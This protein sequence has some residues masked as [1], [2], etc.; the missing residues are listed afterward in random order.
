MT[1]LNVYQCLGLSPMP[2]VGKQATIKEWQ[3]KESEF[4][5]KAIKSQ[6]HGSNIAIRTGARSNCF[7]VDVDVKDRGLEVWNAIEAKHGKIDTYRVNTPNGGLHLYFN[8]AGTQNIGCLQ[9]CIIQSGVKI[10][11]D[12]RNDNG[13]VVAP[14]SKIDDRCYSAVVPLVDY[15][16][17]RGTRTTF[18]PLPDWLR[19]LIVGDCHLDDEYNIVKKEAPPVQKEYDCALVP[20]GIT[21]SFISKLLACFKQERLTI[22]D[23]WRNTIWALQD[24]ALEFSIKNKEMYAL[25]LTHS[26]RYEKYDSSSKRELDNLWDNERKES[27]NL[28]TIRRMAKA[29]NP[30]EYKIICKDITYDQELI[31]TCWND[32]ATVRTSKPTLSKLMQFYKGCVFE[33]NNGSIQYFARMR[34]GDISIIKNPFVARG[35][36]FKIQ[37]APEGKISLR[38]AFETLSCSDAWKRNINTFDKVDFLPSFTEIRQVDGVL[39]LFNG[40]PCKPIQGGSE[41]MEI[42]ED[43]LKKILCAGNADYWQMFQYWLAHLVQKPGVKIEIMPIFQGEQGTGKS[44][45]FDKLF[46][47]LVSAAHYHEI[48]DMNQL[49]D[50]FNSD[51]DKKIICVLNE[52]GTYGKDHG[53]SGKLKSITTRKKMKVEHKGKDKY[54]VSD[55]CNFVLAT[56]MINPVKI[57]TSNR[58]YAPITCSSE[59]IGDVEYFNKLEKAINPDTV[60]RFLYKWLYEI[61]IS[62]WEKSKIPKTAALATMKFISYSSTIRFMLEIASLQIDILDENNEIRMHS[63]VLHSHFAAWCTRNGEPVTAWKVFSTEVI[64]LKIRDGN[65]TIDNVSLKGFRVSLLKL[66]AI[67]RVVIHESNY[68]FCQDELENL[69]DEIAELL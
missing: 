38:A 3:K 41:D 67:L 5:I 16:K 13:Y 48:D 23:E 54:E 61:D 50:K 17:T 57:E 47:I 27:F 37:L 25:A 4:M 64:A 59:R 46:P 51:H 2:V 62:K 26:K 52:I 21:I 15:H 20:Q 39:N 63:S 56:Q 6:K 32:L 14:P 35:E 53:Q 28:G 30:E 10:G 33:I 34:C 7:V 22:R 66:Q 43:H 42:V 49:F 69:D 44:I 18:D 8:Y 55:T 1:D 58:R 31:P 65:V 45:V 24:A 11:I 40:F 12:I 9:A 36:D 60:S 29:D 68:N 19:S